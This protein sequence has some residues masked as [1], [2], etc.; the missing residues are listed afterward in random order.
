MNMY[1]K[2][3]GSAFTLDMTK[4][5]M[6]IRGDGE[7]SATSAKRHYSFVDARNE[8]ERL[9]RKEGVPFYVLEA[10]GRCE[11]ATPVPPVN[12]KGDAGYV[13]QD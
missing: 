12:W 3:S 4:F 5:W 6:V 8:A 7:G 10:I 2:F 9:A 13:W 1:E 11:V